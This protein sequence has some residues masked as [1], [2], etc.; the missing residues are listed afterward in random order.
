MILDRGEDMFKIEYRIVHSENDDF[1]GQNGFLQIKCNENKYGEIYPKE[2][3]MVMDKVSLF[4]WFERMVRVM[5]YLMTKEYVALS[6]VE[7]FNTWI[8]FKKMEAEVVVSIVKAEKKQ[9][10]HDIEFSL[11]D[12]VEGKWGKQVVSYNQLKAEIIEKTREY[13]RCISD[14]KAEQLKSYIYHLDS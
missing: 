4:E 7:S 2:L 14:S 11:D 9:G 13:A 6:D 10:S 3:E 5:Y 8:E 1:L 12:P